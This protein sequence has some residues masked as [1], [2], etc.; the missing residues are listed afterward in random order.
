MSN[1]AAYPGTDYYVSVGEGPHRTWADCARYG[2]VSAGQGAV[3][4]LPFRNNLLPGLR[5]FA[6]QKQERGRGGYVGVGTVLASAVPVA[7]FMVRVGGQQIPLLDTALDAPRMWEH[8]AA[9][10]LSEYVVRVAW[11]HVRSL[12]QGIWETDMR[13]YRR[14]ACR[15]TDPFTLDRLYA[16]FGLAH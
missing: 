11:D 14:T 10:D 1:G 16:R 12:D 7:A 2:F 15:L 5:I 4:S 6:Y 13:A 9:A 8:A 3:Y